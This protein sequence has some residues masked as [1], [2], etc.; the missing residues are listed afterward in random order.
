MEGFHY[1]MFIIITTDLKFVTLSNLQNHVVMTEPQMGEE[2]V[3][4]ATVIAVTFDRDVVTVNSSKLFEVRV[5]FVGV[6]QTAQ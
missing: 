1:L 2:G 5:Y 4:L 6:Y 3:E